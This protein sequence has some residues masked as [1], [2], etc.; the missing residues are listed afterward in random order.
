MNG[1]KICKY[2]QSGCDESRLDGGNHQVAPGGG[3]SHEISFVIF[4]NVLQVAKR[5]GR[6]DARYFVF[7]LC[8]SPV[9][10][11]MNSNRISRFFVVF[12]IT[13]AEHV[14]GH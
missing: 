12:Q 3:G 8:D 1:A 7:V 9:D 5:A 11:P 13:G 14:R 10:I 4:I 2:H 6:V